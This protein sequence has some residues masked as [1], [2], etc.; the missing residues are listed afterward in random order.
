MIG[1]FKKE[2]LIT[3]PAVATTSHDYSSDHGFA[4]LSPPMVGILLSNEAGHYVHSS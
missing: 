3:I 4:G 1:F 2:V